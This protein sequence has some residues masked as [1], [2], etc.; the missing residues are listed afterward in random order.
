[1]RAPCCRGSVGWGDGTDTTGFTPVRERTNS[2]GNGALGPRPASGLG[3]GMRARLP[4]TPLGRAHAAWHRLCDLPAGHSRQPRSGLTTSTYSFPDGRRRQ[5]HGR[6]RTCSSPALHGGWKSWPLEIMPLRPEWALA[7]SGPAE[8][9]P[10]LV[11]DTPGGG[12][13]SSDLPATVEALVSG[14]P[15]HHRRSRAVTCKGMQHPCVLGTAWPPAS[16][17]RPP[18]ERL[19]VPELAKRTCEGTAAPRKAGK[20]GE[21]GARQ[22]RGG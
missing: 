7:G 16:V 21:L 22:G 12:V 13:P 2:N 1:V 10:W 20:P 3:V 9:P 19:P 11:Q 18:A 6:P 15:C 5:S 8:H 4:G 14:C 17:Q